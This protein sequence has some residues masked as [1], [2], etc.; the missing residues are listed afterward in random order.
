MSSSVTPG[1]SWRPRV[2]LVSTYDLGR[3]P[4]GLASPAASLGRAGADVHC[5]D[6]SVEKLPEEEV[7]KAE[8]IAVH[9]PMHT[10]TR[11]AVRAAG[12]MRRLNPRASLCFYGL[13]APLN[14]EHLTRAG[15]DA[16]LG[17][18]FEAGLVELVRAL[19]DPSATPPPGGIRLE[20]LSFEVPDR[21][22][23]PPIDRYARLVMPDGETKPVGYTEA[24]R[25]CKH[26]CRHCP[27]VPV[28]EG[29]FFVVPKDVVLADV[30]QQVAAGARHITFGDP[31][32]FNGPGHALA[33]VRGL[34]EACPD[35]T[36]DVTIK[37]EHLI[38]HA[39][40][41]PVLTETG[42]AFVTSAFES[43]DDGVLGRLEKGHTRAGLVRA[44]EICRGA[45]LSLAPT[46][47][48][49]TP[50][51]TLEGYRALL[52]FIDELDLVPSVAP[53]QLAMRLLIPAG[54]KLLDL[55]K[56]ADTVGPFDPASLAHPW[57][58]DDP[59]VDGLQREVMAL[60]ERAGHAAGRE[61]VFEAIRSLAHGGRAGPSEAASAP[62]R[63]PI[64]YMTEP[65]YC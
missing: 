5:V 28:Y 19:R 6:L 18:E 51:T 60:V 59:R 39:R 26:R 16:V 46:F 2:L 32:F 49:F 24:S 56:M 1:E 31:D 36:Y 8:L 11:I 25:G 27:V 42:C 34:H 9:V 63:A 20:R 23:L 3:Q 58:H 35:L 30:R 21:S 61:G 54:S 48:P 7:S 33:V 4:F 62:R 10:A 40:H 22:G 15:A 57:A 45:G 12:R 38:R 50:W 52:R 17:G 41:L 47:V 13:Y 55:A 37:V 14:A 53:V 29:R 44:V 43:V 64:P 65:W